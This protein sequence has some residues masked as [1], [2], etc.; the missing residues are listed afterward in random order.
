MKSYELTYIISSAISADEAANVAK[1]NETFIQSKEGV[2][3]SSQ[4]SVAQTLAYPIKKQHSGYFVTTIFQA[5]EDK[6]KEL[7]AALESNK[8]ILRSVI[9]IKKPA[10]E[11]KPRR[12]RKPLFSTEGVGIGSPEKKIQKA[13]NPEDLDKK[14][15]ELLT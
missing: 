10:K 4:K 13:V 2:I 15:D 6:L 14:L 5:A 9:L 7:K 11:V 3:L 12:T 1:E 8:S